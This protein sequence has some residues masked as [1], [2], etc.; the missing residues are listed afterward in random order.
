[1]PI[2]KTHCNTHHAKKVRNSNTKT[3][4]RKTCEVQ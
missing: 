1:M 3:T 2:L 4:S